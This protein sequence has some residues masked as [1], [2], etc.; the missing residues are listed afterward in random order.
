MEKVDLVAALCGARVC[1]GDGHPARIL[2]YSFRHPL[3]PVVAAVGVC[4][5][6][7]QVVSC[8]VGVGVV[9]G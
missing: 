5:C 6:L 3:Y 7:R 8:G 1:T 2:C 4:F 9:M